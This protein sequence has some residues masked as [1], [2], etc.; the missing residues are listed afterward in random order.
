MAGARIRIK[1]PHY[2][3]ATGP[4]L[5]PANH[6]TAQAHANQSQ[7][8]LL[9]RPRPSNDHPATNYIISIIVTLSW[10]RHRHTWV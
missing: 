1:H 2:A 5:T 10:W 7:H 4:C 8:A 3:R 6:S 9:I